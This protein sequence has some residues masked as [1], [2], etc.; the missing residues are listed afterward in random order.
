M[1]SRSFP[2]NHKRAEKPF[3]HI[4][5]DLREYPTLSYS[6]YKYFIS[7]LDDCTSIAWI[8]L[9]RKKTEACKATEQF[10]AMIKTQYGVS[11]ME[12]FSDNGGEYVDQDYIDLLLDHGIKI[13]RSILRQPQMNGRTE[14]FN[15]TMDT[16]AEALCFQACLPAS[17]W[18][19]CV[20][21][22]LFLYNRTPARRLDWATPIELADK[23]KPD[24]SKIHVLGCG[25]YIF[26]SEKARAN[27]L[28]PKSE[29]MLFLGYRFGHES[30]M[31]FMCMP[32]N[33]LFYGATALFDE[34]MFPKCDTRKTPTVM[35]IP[36]KTKK[37]KGEE[38]FP[39]VSFEYG[40]D[41][42][43]DDDDNIPYQPYFPPNKPEGTQPVPPVP[44]Q[45]P[46][47]PTGTVPPPLPP[48]TPPR[49][50]PFRGSGVTHGRALGRGRG[51]GTLGP[52]PGAAGPSTAPG[53]ATTKDG[54]C[55][56]QRTR[57]VP[58]HPGNVYPEGTTVDK[59]LRKQPWKG[60]SV[61]AMK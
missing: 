3:Q 28:T 30:N 55:R 17:Y 10:I 14:Q 39:V 12:W 33:V 51:H 11:I 6:K 31:I 20:L 54:P 52:A 40:F 25:A 59:D 35:H 8:I 29:L 26:I 21:H 23:E 44:P 9:L 32:N 50:T 36:D 15:Q 2:V 27:K 19:F 18:E 43:D 13:F 56:S 46:T 1:R 7:F 5:S 22:G 38:K 42:S 16:K 60:N 58:H 37:S 34:T 53:G 24:L 61:L 41:S 48:R 4:H 57:N 45:P 47:G 49:G